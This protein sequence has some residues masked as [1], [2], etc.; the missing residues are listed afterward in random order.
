[1]SLARP[2]RL[3]VAEDEPPALARLC[4]ALQRVAPAAVVHGTAGSVAG[5]RAWLAAHPPPDLML[6]DIQLADGLSLALFDSPG[7]APS[8]PVVFTTAHDAFVLEAFRC[9]AI[10]YLLKP[11]GDAALAAALVRY[12]SLSR[13]FTGNLAGLIASLAPQLG[14]PGAGLP[15]RPAWRQRLVLRRGSGFA[16]VR[17]DEVAWCVSVD[18]LAFVVTTAGERLLADETLA[19]L[20]AALDP[21]QFFRVNRQVLVR[22]DAVRGFRPHGKG[23]L[24]LELQPA[25]EAP[26]LVSQERARAF[27]EWMQG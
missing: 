24:R 1:V 5:A 19:E 25:H 4:E 3:F 18:K 12:E 10:D 21:A 22:L 26:V 27:K 6:L 20:E 15:P 13:H 7:A 8:V 11:V 17:S 23:Q 16:S 14:G 2:L 9:N